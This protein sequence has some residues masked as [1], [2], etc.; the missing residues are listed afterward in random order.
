MLTR[1]Y[2]IGHTSAC[3]LNPAVSVGLV[4]GGCLSV[5]DLPAKLCLAC[6]RDR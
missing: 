3:H 1:V 5:A 4:A 2:A 6:G